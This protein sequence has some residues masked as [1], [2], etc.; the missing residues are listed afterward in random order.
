MSFTY[1]KSVNIL[2]ETRKQRTKSVSVLNQDKPNVVRTG[3]PVFT[4]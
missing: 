3:K 4:G 2:R 1:V